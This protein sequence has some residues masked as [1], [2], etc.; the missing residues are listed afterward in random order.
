ET[1]FTGLDL[2]ANLQ[3]TRAAVREALRVFA[4]AGP[5]DDRAPAALPATLSPGEQSEVNEGCYE[6]LLILAEA[7]AQPMPG[8]AATPQARQ[9]LRILDQ[10]ARLRPEP[11]RAHHL[12]RADCLARVGDE[13]GEARAT[14]AAKRLEPLTAHDH[15]VDGQEHYRRGRWSVAL[16][17]FDATL[18]L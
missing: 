17:H 10:A 14:E 7:V 2:P 12:R 16:G 6:L 11:T 1:R 18:R 5:D 9:G 15:F 8:Q 4:G 13:D 3:A